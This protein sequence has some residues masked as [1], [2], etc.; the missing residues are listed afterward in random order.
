[1]D[2]WFK[3]SLLNHKYKERHCNINAATQH[4]NTNLLHFKCKLNWMSTANKSG[5]MLLNKQSKQVLSGR[6]A[7]LKTGFYW[8]IYPSTSIGTLFLLEICQI[9]S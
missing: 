8:T 9:T 6:T 3:G 2:Q 5:M 1:M 7:Y 4:L